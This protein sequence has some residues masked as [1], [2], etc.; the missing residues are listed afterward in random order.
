MRGRVGGIRGHAVQDRAGLGFRGLA[1]DQAE[2]FAELP[3]SYRT[4]LVR[5]RATALHRQL[6]G[7]PRDQLGQALTA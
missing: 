5:S 6:S 7:R 1:G 3:D 2:A 4:G